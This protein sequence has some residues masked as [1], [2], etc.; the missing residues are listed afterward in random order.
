[1]TTTSWR[2]ETADA[3]LA[4][5]AVERSK[6][7]PRS[8]RRVVSGY[9]CS[10]GAA[11]DDVQLLPD[12]VWQPTADAYIRRG[13]YLCYEH[14][15]LI[16]LVERTQVNEHGM[17]IVA[18]LAAGGRL[19]EEAWA[20]V[21]SGVLQGLSVRFTG[22]DDELTIGPVRIPVSPRILEVSLCRSPSDPRCRFL[23][24]DHEPVPPDQLPRLHESVGTLVERVVVARRRLRELAGGER[25]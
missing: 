13:A 19:A 9:A 1:M 21:E 11:L 20:H 16:G 25:G 12:T 24:G 2:T 8:D 18:R 7:G 4:R 23:V 15:E 6:L 17:W 5:L 3:C 22:R 10:F 14:Q